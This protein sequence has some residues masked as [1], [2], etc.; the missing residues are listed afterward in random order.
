MSDA[1]LEFPI[2][3]ECPCCHD[4]VPLFSLSYIWGKDTTAQA[5]YYCG[6]CGSFSFIGRTVL[7]CKLT[8]EVTNVDQ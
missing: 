7:Y 2:K 6:K 1:K 4:I 8:K 5:S 3:N